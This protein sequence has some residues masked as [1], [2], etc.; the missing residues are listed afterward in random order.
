M[1]AL[2]LVLAAALP[3]GLV[4]YLDWLAQRRTGYRAPLNY[5]DRDN[6]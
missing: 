3:H 5:G 1:L 6:D 4:G 2:Y